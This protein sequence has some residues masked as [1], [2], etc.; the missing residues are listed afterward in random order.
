MMPSL[1]SPPPGF[2]LHKN[3]LFDA[4]R[5]YAALQVM[6]SHGSAYL[7]ID[8]PPPV[9]FIFNM[10]PGVPVFFSISGF[11]VGL[12]FL[13]MRA[14]YALY[15][16]HRMVRIY[17]A[18]LACL[19]ITC[20]LLVFSGKDSFLFSF[21]GILWLVCQSTFLQ[22]YNPGELRDFGIG[23][24]NGSLWTIPVELQFYVV[25]PFIVAVALPLG[26]VVLRQMRVWFFLISIVALSLFSYV[27]M[28][29]LLIN[30]S[31]FA[32]KLLRVTIIP[33]L[34]QFVFGF[35]LIPLLFAARR[36][37]VVLVCLSLGIL[38]AVCAFR[39]HQFVP[40]SS[41]L[42]YAL[43]AVGVG[44]VPVR[45]SLGCDLSYGIYLYHG[46][47]INLLY[48]LDLSLP[49]ILTF[50]SSL[51]ISLAAFS[52]FCVEKPAMRAMHDPPIWLLRLFRSC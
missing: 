27:L 18:L 2:K 40:L 38:F 14:N 35:L 44:L 33:H 50:Y 6:L 34:Y 22:F 29:Y 11:L 1:F 7:G 46:L 45:G 9:S 20:L 28:N 36:L 31:I 37:V 4:V 25:L 32:S 51:T 41:S 52:W 24:V 16:W 13:R 12:S 21:G 39:F 10:F 42:S 15:I 48:R 3:N 23:V 8:I 47:C 30:G 5:L 19:L 26:A 49:S 17:P 43:L